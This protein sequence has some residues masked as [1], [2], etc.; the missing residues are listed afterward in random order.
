MIR[1]ESTKT[2]EQILN[3]IKSET[4]KS[5]RLILHNDDVNSIDWVVK[6][7]MDICDHTPEQAEQ[8][9][10]LAHHKGKT[11]AKVGD[12]D[13]LLPMKRGLNE[14]KIEATIETIE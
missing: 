4:V 10:M 2:I 5:H 14:R 7:L 6:S 13:S 11:E 3:D 9:A 8:V 12:L 1:N